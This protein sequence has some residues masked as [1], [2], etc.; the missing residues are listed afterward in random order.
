MCLWYHARIKTLTTEADEEA[1][2]IQTVNCAADYCDETNCRYG[3]VCLYD[4]DGFKG[5]TC[6]F[7]CRSVI[8]TRLSITTEFIR[9]FC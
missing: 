9:S 6:Q 1:K 2:K 8:T 5:C 7:D 3:G 4:A